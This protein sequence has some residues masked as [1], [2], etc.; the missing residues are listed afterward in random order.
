MTAD[1][2]TP[3]KLGKE[4]RPSTMGRLP[5]IQEPV[6]LQYNLGF[7]CYIRLPMYPYYSQ[8][9]QW[10]GLPIAADPTS[11]K[12]FG[13]RIADTNAAIIARKAER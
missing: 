7:D 12:Y 2:K 10:P 1:T 4:W 5:S 11:C 3:T 9:A 6:G 13:P 8:T